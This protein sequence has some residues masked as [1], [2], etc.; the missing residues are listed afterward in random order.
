MK[1]TKIQWC[2]STINPVMGCDGCELWKSAPAIAAI[3]LTM[4][5]LLTKKPKATLR[6]AIA[7]AVGDRKTSE[8]YRDRERVAEELATRLNLPREQQK[9]VVDVVRRQCKCY[10]GL[11]GT[12]RAG[13]AGYADAFESPKHYPGRVAN[14]AGWNLPDEREILHK[15]WLGGLPRLIFIS[16]MGDALSKSVSFDYLGKRSFGMSVLLPAASTF[17]FG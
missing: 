4:L 2:H 15:P 14:A 13:H 1:Y 5:I 16:D 7:R 12:F 17:G 10:A 6:Q 8:L 11:L 3:M 9:Q